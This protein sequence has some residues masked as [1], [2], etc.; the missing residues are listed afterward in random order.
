MFLHALSVVVYIQY[1]CCASF[2]PGS[3]QQIMP[4]QKSLQLRQYSHLMS[5]TPNHRQVMKLKLKLSYDHLS[6]GQSILVSG[7]HLELVTRFFF[8]C[9][10]N[11]GF[12]DVWRP[13]WRE[14]GCVIYSY[15][16]F[17]A[18]PEVSLSG[19]SP[20]ELTTIFYCLI[21]DRQTQTHLLPSIIIRYS[22]IP[23]HRNR[24]VLLKMKKETITQA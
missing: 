11:C 2:S 15:I 21:W 13:L 19:K 9:I 16:C 4:C 6:I 17:W 7:S 8:F 10:D 14:D 23:G 3:V 5:H 20:A 12:L 22:E 18:L 1:I 24:L